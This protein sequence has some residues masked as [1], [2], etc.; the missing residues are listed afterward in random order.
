MVTTC[1][2]AFVCCCDPKRS[3]TALP[4]NSCDSLNKLFVFFV[5]L[6]LFVH[7]PL[8]VGIDV[9]VV[10]RGNLSGLADQELALEVPLGVLRSGF[11]PQVLPELGSFVPLDLSELH[12][13]PRKVFRLGEFRNRFVGFVL[14]KS[15]FPGREADDHE[16]IAVL[17]IELDEL[18]VLLLG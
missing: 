8:N 16:L 18:F 11:L 14:L 1:V 3:L 6:E 7:E 15:V 4:P 5:L 12:H 13:D 17:F 10:R 9:L 2:C